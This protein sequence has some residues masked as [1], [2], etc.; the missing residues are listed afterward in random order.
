MG[1]IQIGRAALDHIPEILSIIHRSFEQYRGLL[2]PPSGAHDETLET[3]RLKMTGGGAMV[4][5]AVGNRAAGCALWKAEATH[6]Y[7][8]RLG[9]LPEWR[10]HGV[11]TM[12]LRAIE[13][14]AIDLHLPRIE[15][16]IRT[17]LP[18][19]QSYYERNGY[20][21][22]ANGTHQGYTMPTYLRMEKYLKAPEPTVA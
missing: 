11:G 10:G 15:L 16:G 7:L 20:R 13:D 5:T 4:A 2:D 6:L 1:N 3:L 14:L 9:V 8:G 21:V 22:F 18:Y 17:S 19:L 12:L